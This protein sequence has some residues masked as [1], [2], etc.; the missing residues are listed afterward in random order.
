MDIGRV[1]D[2]L[3]GANLEGDRESPVSWIVAK[4]LIPFTVGLGTH[5]RLLVMKGLPVEQV[6][7]FLD[8]V[9]EMA[10]VH[11]ALMQV[12]FLWVPSS[13]RGAQFGEFDKH[14]AFL[15]ALAKIAKDRDAEDKKDMET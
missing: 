5:W 1:E 6:E 7:S 11:M 2:I 4:D 14:A 12:R 9:A 3:F 10:Y 15:K 8:S 13:S